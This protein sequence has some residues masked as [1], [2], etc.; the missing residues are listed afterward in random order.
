[1]SQENVQILR[2]A[3]ERW[4]SGDMDLTPDLIDP[5]CEVRSPLSSVSGEPYRGIPGYRR[6]IAD[7][8]DHFEEWKVQA[9]EI[10]TLSDGRLLV[11][12]SVHLRGRGSGVAFDQPVGW[13]IGVREGRLLH[14]TIYQDHA[15]ALKAVGLEE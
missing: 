11:L 12:G 3:F 14:L 1:M 13:L 2:R 9:D 10:R 15:D 6:W 4:N 7:I 8:A 5:A